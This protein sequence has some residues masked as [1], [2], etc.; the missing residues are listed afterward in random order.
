[1]RIIC[2]TPDKGDRPELLDKC[3]KLM[4]DQSRRPDEH[5]TITS[6]DGI[7]GNVRKG[8]QQAIDMGADIIPIIE[9]DDFYP[10]NYIEL[11]ESKWEEDAMLLGFSAT[12]YYHIKFRMYRNM[13]HP[14]RASLMQTVFSPNIDLSL[15]P[16]DK[17][18]FLDLHIWKQ[19]VKKILLPYSPALGIKH[20]IG[21]SGGAAHRSSFWMTDNPQNISDPEMRY[22]KSKTGSDPFYVDMSQRMQK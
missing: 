22:L 21:A 13:M 7:T 2:V 9:N 14:S 15:F 20:G 10:Q 16:D 3:R 18:K 12:T 1:M 8:I 6:D 11:I 4:S 17:E 5:I 19:D